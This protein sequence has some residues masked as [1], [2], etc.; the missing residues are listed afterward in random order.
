MQWNFT[1]IRITGM[2]NTIS[3]P[4]TRSLEVG[5]MPKLNKGHNSSKFIEF[6][7]EVNQVIYSSAQ[8]SICHIL[9]SNLRCLVHKVMFQHSKKGHN[10]AIARS[11]RKDKNTGQLIVHKQLIN[12]ISKP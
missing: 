2:S 6:Y 9:K 7:P 8:N 5:K 1:F 12:E 10:S 3:I 4:K 11:T